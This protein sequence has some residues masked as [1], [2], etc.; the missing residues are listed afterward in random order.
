MGA[1]GA[2]G[3]GESVVGWVCGGGR[4]EVMYG[5]VCCLCMG[6]FC[7]LIVGLGSGFLCEDVALY[8]GSL[9]ID[10]FIWI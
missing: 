1:V 10:G 7:V 8:R 6:W 3:G 5:Y 9:L 4:G 2:A